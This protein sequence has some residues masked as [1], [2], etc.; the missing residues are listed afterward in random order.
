MKIFR[1][2][3]AVFWS[4]TLLW[5]TATLMGDFYRQHPSGWDVS[6]IAFWLTL[7]LVSIGLIALPA[8]AETGVIRRIVSLWLQVKKA[9][10]RKELQ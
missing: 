5:L 8:R 10:L 7:A 9:E 3:V 6:V 4:G 2:V 1:I